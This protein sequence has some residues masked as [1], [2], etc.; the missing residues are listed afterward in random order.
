MKLCFFVRFI[1]NFL[2]NFLKF[3]KSFALK[4]SM[5]NLRNSTFWFLKF[6]KFVKKSYINLTKKQNFIQKN[7]FGLK[8]KILSRIH[9]KIKNFWLKNI[10]FKIKILNFPGSFLVFIHSVRIHS[11]LLSFYFRKK[12]NLI[13]FKKKSKYKKKVQ[14]MNNIF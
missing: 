2:T 8:I 7:N 9:Q 5:K 11:N 10:K 4:N 14:K 6:K 1:Y 3:Q 12:S 13:L